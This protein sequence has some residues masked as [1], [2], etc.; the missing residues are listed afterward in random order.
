MIF[1]ANLALDQRI[2]IKLTEIFSYNLRRFL[3]E[4][5]SYQFE[6]FFRDC[7]KI[8]SDFICCFPL[9]YY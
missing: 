1:L 8:I 9:S 5:H 3:F 7:Y 4:N 6:C 2:Q